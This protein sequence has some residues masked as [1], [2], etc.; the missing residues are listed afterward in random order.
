MIEALKDCPADLNYQVFGA[1]LYLLG[2]V[3]FWFIALFFLFGIFL[4]VKG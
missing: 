1:F 3:A 4:L 2:S